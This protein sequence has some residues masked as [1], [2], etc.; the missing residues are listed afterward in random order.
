[1]TAGEILD[2]FHG[3]RALVVG[4]LMLDEYIFGRA[5]RI[6][7]EAPVMVVRQ[8][9]TRSVPGGAANVAKNLV[10][11]GAETTLLGVVGDDSAGHALEAALVDAGTGRVEL[12]RDPSRPTTRKTRVLA[13]SAHQVLRIDHEEE[14]PLAPALETDLIQRLAAWVQGIDVVIL[15]DYVKGTLTARVCRAT[16]DLCRERGVTCVANAKPQSMGFY[17]GADLVSLNRPETADAA[18]MPSLLS[19]SVAEVPTLAQAAAERARVAIG[20]AHLLATM[21]GAGMATESF[22]IAAPKVD[23]FDT[24]GAGDTVIATV[25]LGLRRAGFR[26]EVFALAAQTSAAVV[27]KVGVA[28]PT[29]EDLTAIRD[30]A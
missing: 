22:W 30:L 13:D 19:A 6:S 3:V 26:P 9:S 17:G 28:V 12:L 11:L 29:P 1:V 27:R 16:I 14:T 25:A 10:A 24:A 2:S 8:T 4:D 20:V 21:G 23:V 15:S 18:R 5:T 7:Q